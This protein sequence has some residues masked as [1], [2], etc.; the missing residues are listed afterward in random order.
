M[1]DAMECYEFD[2]II[3]SGRFPGEGLDLPGLTP[4]FKKSIHSLVV[5]GVD[6]AGVGPLAGP[7]VAAAVIL[8][9]FPRIDGLN[10]SKALTPE[11]RDALFPKIKSVALATAVSI[12][13]VE[14][15]D[16][17]NILYATLH[18]M[19]EAIRKLSVKPDLVLVDGRNKPGSGLKEWALVK[20]D[21]K[22]ASI[23]AAS[24]LAK[25][26]R[27]RL[28]LEAH[29]QFP[30]Y[31]FNEHKGYGSKKH[32]DALIEH[33]PCPLHRKSFEPVRNRLSL[34]DTGLAMH[35]SGNSHGLMS[36]ATLP[37]YF[38]GD[39]NPGKVVARRATLDSLNTAAPLCGDVAE[40]LIKKGEHHEGEK[41]ILAG[42]RSA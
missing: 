6:E 2:R 3:S 8:P 27:D 16:K 13:S 24:I 11:K 33:G 38:S 42:E 20:G 21:T 12:V 23:M 22:S 30:M 35:H 41:P 19:R 39:T 28:M 31:A 17:M 5:A 18:A 40:S 34:E 36:G 15:I 1:W 26:T 25:V 7:V 32:M 14:T 9:R 10:D 37:Q 29:V 4:Q